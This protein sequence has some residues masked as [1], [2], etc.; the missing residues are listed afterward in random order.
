M[1]AENSDGSAPNGGG[2]GSES[3][4]E[5]YRRAID[6]LRLA[7][8]EDGFLASPTNEANYRAVWCRD[9]V[10]MGLAA[11]LSGLD[12]L[13]ETFRRTLTTLADHRGPHGE[14]PSNVN[15]GTG[16]ISYGGTTGRVDADLWYV[17]GCGE[18]WRATGDDDTLRA[19][20]PVLEGIRFLL[21]AWE[22]NNRGLLYVPPTGDWADEYL[23]TGYV[24]YDQL[25]YL[26]AQRTFQTIHRHLHGTTDEELAART[27]R[28][29]LLIRANYWLGTP[30]EPAEGIYH[31]VLYRKGRDAVRC[32]S[33]RHWLPFFSPTGYGYR[34]DALA[35][36]LVSLLGIASAEQAQAVDRVLDEI[37]PP[38]LP[39][40]PA[41]HPVIRPVD[42][43]WEE[44]HMSFS[45]TFKNNPYEYHNGGLWPY[46]TAFRAVELARRGDS[47]G[48]ARCRDAIHRANALPMDGEEWSFPE[49]V[50]GREFD[51][52]GTRFQGWSAAGAVIAEHALRG[53]AL[54][55]IDGDDTSPRDSGR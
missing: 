6:L 41:F 43:D 46:I 12:D 10:I 34:F 8:T 26:Q 28:L 49:Y 21:G 13:R 36:I 33:R 40:V 11:L 50:H 35:N 51:A 39:L 5:G 29:A 47:D 30:D 55:R 9:G 54:L 23:H 53:E 16:R 22:Y 52:R 32:R 19:L 18:Y 27:R 42:K 31:E 3:H 15:A 38:A 44:L 17:I 4:R 7:R 37:C 2:D 45:Y 20:L 25:L 24:L 1:H 14:I 48:A